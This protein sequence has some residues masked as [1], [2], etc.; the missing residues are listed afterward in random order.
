M[1]NNLEGYKGVM[2]HSFCHANECGNCQ[3]YRCP[4]Q[5]GMKRKIARGQHLGGRK[6]NGI[7]RE[8][9]VP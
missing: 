2:Q 3:W 5:E 1:Q 9:E 4:K 6:V 7:S 8:N